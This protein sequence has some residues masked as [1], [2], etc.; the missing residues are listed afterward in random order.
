MLHF[1]NLF[2]KILIWVIK[3]LL[4]KSLN[5]A[6]NTNQNKGKVFCSVLQPSLCDILALTASS[7]QFLYVNK[8]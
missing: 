8:C 4:F 2:I 7:C 3:C 5:I 1:V 6:I